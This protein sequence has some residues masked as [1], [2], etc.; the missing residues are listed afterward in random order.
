[1]RMAGVPRELTDWLQRRFAG[2]TTRLVFDDFI[3]E[4][5]RI[6]IGLDQG[7]PLS[8]TA[9]VKSV[10][11]KEDGADNW[12]ETHNSEFGEAKDQGCHFSQRRVLQ[13]RPF[14]PS[15]WVPEPRPALILRGKRVK[16]ESAV[17]LVGIWIDEKLTFKEQAAAA[18]AKG[19]AWLVQF[20]RLARVSGGV[21]AT[22]IRQLYL[23]I[24]IPRM[25]YGAEVW[26]VPMYQ[27]KRGANRVQ[28]GR[29]IVKKLASIQLRAAR[30]ILG[31]MVSSPGDMLDAHADL[32]PMHL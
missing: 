23:A 22:Y 17:K 4:I 9:A 32:M 10:V 6:V 30:M 13:A 31:G 20:R 11:E 27:R 19:Q 2:R 14:Q 1:M 29:A 18:L 8:T 25:F 5:V 16:M 15:I 21:G 7:D 26:L 3:S 28:D 12:G 24:C